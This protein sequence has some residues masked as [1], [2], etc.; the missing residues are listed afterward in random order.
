M[1]SREKRDQIDPGR[2]AVTFGALSDET[3]LR[4]LLMLEV[5]PRSVNEIVDFFTLTQP[6]ISRHLHV[7]KK[8]GLVNV[9]RQGQRKRYS[10]NESALKQHGAGYFAMF[11]CCATRVGRGE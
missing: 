10:L 11:R 4:I 3:R 7:L 9:E 1:A 8:A 2:S 6:T 5:R